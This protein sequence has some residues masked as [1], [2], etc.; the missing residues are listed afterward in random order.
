M[1][2]MFTGRSL[3]VDSLKFLVSLFV[4]ERSVIVV[5]AVAVVVVLGVVVVA[6]DVDDSVELVRSTI[7]LSVV[8]TKS[9]PFQTL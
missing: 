3:V 6:V 8:I 7:D 5:V 1:L 9:N 4:K 2:L